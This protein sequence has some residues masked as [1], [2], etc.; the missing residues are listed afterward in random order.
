MQN[1]EMSGVQYYNQDRN[2]ILNGTSFI[3]DCLPGFE[4]EDGNERAT[5]TCY[6]GQLKPVPD[7]CYPSKRW[8]FCDIVLR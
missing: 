8:F 6:E 7:Q 1:G 4:T 3:V 5:V 2:R